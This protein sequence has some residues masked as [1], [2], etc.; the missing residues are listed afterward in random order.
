MKIV[1][2]DGA[3]VTGGDLSFDLFKQFGEVVIYDL[4]APEEIAERIKDADIVLCNKTPMTAEVM[5][6]AKNLKYIGLFAT[7]YNNIDIS[8]TIIIYN[9]FK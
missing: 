4:T 7:G 8:T 2:T 1:I 5:K 6:D 3:T 9:I